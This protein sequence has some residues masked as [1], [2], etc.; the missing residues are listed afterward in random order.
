MISTVGLCVAL[1]LGEVRVSSTAELRQALS[2]A[3]PATRIVLAS[4]RYE[5]FSFAG[6]SGAASKPVTIASADPGAPAVFTGGVQ[7][8][9]VA[10]LVLEDLVFDGAAGNGLNIDDGGTF[11][12][13]SEHIVLRRVRVRDCGGAGNHDGIKLSG[14]REF[15][16][17]ECVVERWGRGGSAVDMVGCASGVL[18]ACE[19][20]DSERNPASN[21]VQAKG[22]SHAIRIEACRFEH[23]GQRAVNLGGSTGLEFFRPR[24]AGFEARDISVEGCTFIGS[25]APIAFVGVDGAS[26]R[27][28][29]IYRPQ[30]WVARIL[31]ETRA[32]GFVPCRNGVFSDNLIVY[33][34]E[35]L[36]TA[37]NVGDATA[38]ETFQFARNWW[39]CE[40]EPARARPTL[41][42]SELDSA[43]G[44]DPQFLDAAAL[45]LRL[46]QESPARA[47]GADAW[48]RR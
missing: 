18:S 37:V 38:P 3:R 39:F 2:N 35:E 4:A 29:T 27:F 36:A 30:R 42:V 21:A 28:N 10:H 17:E 20:R 26:V 24:P 12:T 40:D 15:R 33:R 44:R 19:F 25:L 13:P 5:G 32:E 34:R 41:P 16:L 23:A 47:H 6:V 9:D 45:D 7:L 22:G 1:A 48:P 31:Q 8:S 11:E 46:A 14:V 43:G